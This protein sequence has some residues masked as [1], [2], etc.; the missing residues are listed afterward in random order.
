MVIW[1]TRTRG[2]FITKVLSIAPGLDKDE[3]KNN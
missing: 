3:T 1:H 2:V